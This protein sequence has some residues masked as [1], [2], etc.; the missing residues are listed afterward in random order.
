MDGEIYLEIL[1]TRPTPTRY[2]GKLATGFAVHYTILP[3]HFL[4]I[5][6]I[7]L[8]PRVQYFIVLLRLLATDT[9]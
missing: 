4:Y 3:A 7:W 2:C 9:I 6:R 1:V 8:V 5:F